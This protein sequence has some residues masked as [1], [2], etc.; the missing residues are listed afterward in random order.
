MSNISDIV[1]KCHFVGYARVENDNGKVGYLVTSKEVTIPKK[2]ETFNEEN[3]ESSISISDSESIY[4]PKQ[5]MN[6]LYFGISSLIKENEL[7]KEPLFVLYTQRAGDFDSFT[8]NII[9]MVDVSDEY[10][11]NFIS[12][13]S[14]FYKRLCDI[15]L[16]DA[17][18]LKNQPFD[19]EN[20]LS[21]FKSDFYNKDNQFYPTD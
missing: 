17:A 2:N 8:Y 11:I 4:F 19:T 21:E 15:I 1:G 9:N 10:K 13:D 5:G 14:C 6:D 3:S 16:N 7:Y 12:D 20:K 18:Q